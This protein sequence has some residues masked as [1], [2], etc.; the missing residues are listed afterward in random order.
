MVA[1]FGVFCLEIWFGIYIGGFGNTCSTNWCLCTNFQFPML[2]SI[3]LYP[4]LQLILI[5]MERFANRLLKSWKSKNDLYIFLVTLILKM[6]FILSKI[7][8]GPSFIYKKIFC[9]NFTFIDCCR[10][11]EILFL[12]SKTIIKD[13][14]Q[15]GKSDSFLSGHF[16]SI[17]I[18]KRGTT[19]AKLL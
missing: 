3:F 16:L 14:S 19:K 2:I 12:C 10:F 17:Q 4:A 7:F 11:L 13:I 8:W 9:T 5:F 1:C 18:Q 15:P 6:Y